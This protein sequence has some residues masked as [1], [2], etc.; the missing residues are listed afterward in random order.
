RNTATI[1][2]GT[3]LTS[4]VSHGSIRPAGRPTSAPGG[5]EFKRSAAFNGPSALARSRRAS[6][7]RSRQLGHALDELQQRPLVAA[8]VERDLV[9][10][11]VLFDPHAVVDHVGELRSPGRRQSEEGHA[12]DQLRQDPARLLGQYVGVEF[13]LA[14]K[15]GD[16]SALDHAN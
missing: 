12:T 8:V 14:T 13:V 16:A 10:A 11:A 4:R 2:A 3:S 9:C 1:S 15:P 6:A 5:A 7:Q